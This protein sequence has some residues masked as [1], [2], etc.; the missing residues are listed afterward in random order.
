MDGLPFQSAF[1]STDARIGIFHAEWPL[2][3]HWWTTSSICVRSTTPRRSTRRS[4]ATS[5]SV[6][7]TGPAVITGEAI[8]TRSRARPIALAIRCESSSPCPA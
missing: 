3:R 2:V 4:A 1:A 8:R 7:S 6:A 5:A